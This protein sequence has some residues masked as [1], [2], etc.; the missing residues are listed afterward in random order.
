MDIVAHGESELEIAYQLESP[1][2]GEAEIEDRSKKLDYGTSCGIR[3]DSGRR[4]FL[5]IAAGE[6]LQTVRTAEGEG[7]LSVKD[8]HCF[9]IDFLACP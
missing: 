7:V 2:W 3:S 4:E 8:G 5:E 6:L 9:R 1:G